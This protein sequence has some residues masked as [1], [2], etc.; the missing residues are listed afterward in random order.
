M[1]LNGFQLSDNDYY[2]ETEDVSDEEGVPEELR[3]SPDYEELM[4]LKRIRREKE[5]EQREGGIQPTKHFGYKCDGCGQDPILGGRFT[6]VDC[7]KFDHSIDYCCECAPT[8]SRLKSIGKEFG[9]TPDHNFR[10]VRK[11][12]DSMQWKRKHN[13][14]TR[15]KDYMI[16]ATMGN[17]LD[18]NYQYF[19]GN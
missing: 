13:G 3:K 12:V 8:V 4:W 11:R 15:D 1:K 19:N 16:E 6:C 14:N 2:L 18:P 17:Y 9:H 10:P 5:L 7:A